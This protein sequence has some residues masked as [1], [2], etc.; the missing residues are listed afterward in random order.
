[1]SRRRDTVA[2]S[3][4]RWSVVVLTGLV[5]AG[6]AETVEPPPS[7][8]TVSSAPAT[9]T[10]LA[11]DDYAAALVDAT[12]AVRV[13]AGV[14]VL[15][16]SECA[17]AQAQV[18]AED[19]AAAGGELVHE[20]LTPVSDACAPVV[21]SGENLS[22]AA[23]EPEAIVDAWMDSPGHASNL[24]M[25]EY[26]EIGIGCVAFTGAAGSEMLCSQV[27]LGR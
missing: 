6:C 19:L 18:R 12:N 26:T 20:P 15:E 9:P 23:A 4:V 8:P 5:C 13:D 17:R 22:R 21:I 27:F 7:G 11:P 16:P 24:L 10:T 2:R 14:A 1:M 25:P 3:A